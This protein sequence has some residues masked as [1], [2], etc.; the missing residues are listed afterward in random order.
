MNLLLVGPIASGKGTQAEKLITKY[1]LAH[2][3]M[4]RL[5]RV[6][7]KEE[8]ETGQ[9]VRELLDRGSLIPDEI[10]SEVVNTHLQSVNRL[11]GILFDGFPRILSQAKYFEKFMTEKGVKIDMVI[12]LTLPREEIFKRLAN[13][14]TC[15]Q[16]G[17]V[18]N[19]ST[20]P[21]MVGGI[22]D[23]CGGKLVSRSDESPEKSAVRIDWF[24]KQVIP[25]INY[26]R[27]KGMVEEVDGNRS[28]EVIFEDIVSRLEKRGL[29]NA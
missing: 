8:T 10:A 17:K 27:S 26:Y 11:K 6:I 25:M 1:S 16:C 24:E 19:L 15:E 5:L 12:Y 7:S 28:I 23:D 14:R 9:R 20:K 3:E 21:P 22:C 4:G 29:T 13:R 18:Y 2:V